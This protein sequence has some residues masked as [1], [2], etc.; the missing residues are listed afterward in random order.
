MLTVYNTQKL[1]SYKITNPGSSAGFRTM[2]S[3]G[4]GRVWQ[5]RPGLA[6]AGAGAPV[7]L[8]LPSNSLSYFFLNFF[9]FPP[10]FCPGHISGTVARRDSKLSVLLGPAV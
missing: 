2:D 7:S 8:Y 3:R 10:R 6:G 4:R 9:L 5:K 1:L